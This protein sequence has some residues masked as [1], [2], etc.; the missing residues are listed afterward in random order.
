[1][2]PEL[3]DRDPVVAYDDLTVQRALD[4]LK[5]RGLARFVHPASGERAT[6]FRHIAGDAIGLERDE[7]A[8]VA[9]LVLRGPQT[10]G[11]LRTR[12]ERQHPFA[13]T[14]EVESALDPARPS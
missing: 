9:V 8:I 1:M 11:E 5:A 7:L 3:L 13:S 12:T 6:K 14:E 10:A 4:S 2:Q